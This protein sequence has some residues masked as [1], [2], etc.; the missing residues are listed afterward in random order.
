MPLPPGQPAAHLYP[1]P[2]PVASAQGAGRGGNGGG[3]GRVLPQ[4]EPP[5]LISRWSPAC[6]VGTAK[7][8]SLTAPEGDRSQLPSLH[9]IWGDPPR[10]R[11]SQGARTENM[12]LFLPQRGIAFPL[13][14]SEE[15]GEVV[16][17]L[18]GGRPGLSGLQTS[19]LLGSQSPLRWVRSQG[20]CC[21]R[22]HPSADLPRCP[23]A[24]EAQ[25]GQGSSWGLQPSWLLFVF[26]C[27]FGSE[28]QSTVTYQFSVVLPAAH[29]RP[30][31]HRPATPPRSP[32]HVSALSLEQPDF[33][34]TEEAEEVLS[35]PGANRVPG[36]FS[37]LPIPGGLHHACRPFAA[38]LTCLP[39]SGQLSH[40][41]SSRKPSLISKP[42]TALSLPA[43]APAE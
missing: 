28:E 12:T 25:E 40:V 39:E 14:I 1:L 17:R 6:Y 43:P 7:A 35:A 33:Q 9:G 2:L 38:M 13:L 41:T 34:P 20:P 23:G 32:L 5:A 37:S 11:C 18:E 15:S 8:S 19:T 24:G 22:P 4:L 31:P 26:K 29:R 21:S 16:E 30:P 27:V 36:S 42:G 3:G 10:P